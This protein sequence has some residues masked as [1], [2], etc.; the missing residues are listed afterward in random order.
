MIQ[1]VNRSGFT[2]VELMLAMAFVGILILS[3]AMVTIQI[4]NSYNRGLTLREVS[5]AGRTVSDDINRSVGASAPIDRALDYNTTAS[6]GRLCLGLH[7]YVWNY[8]SALKASGVAGLYKYQDG[9]PIRLARV[10]DPGKSLCASPSSL[11]DRSVRES[12]DLLGDGDR[13][14]VV[15]EFNLLPGSTINPA[16]GQG[17]HAFKF[18]IGTNSGGEAIAS[19]NCLPPDN[20]L[21]QLDYCAMNSFEIVVRSSNGAGE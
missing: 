7:T 13:N 8:G 17:L 5:Q 9:T 14:L 20:A 3:I 18:L 2:I 11:I 15:H 16:T 19:S 6:G 4:G 1:R 10:S 12:V 21:S